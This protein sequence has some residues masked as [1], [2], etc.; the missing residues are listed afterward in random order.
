[1]STL[2]ENGHVVT[3]NAGREVFDGGYVL[4]GDDGRIT[5]AGPAGTAPNP[6]CISPRPNACT[7]DSSGAPWN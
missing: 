1:M 5:S 3:M 6:R 2:I 7:F 4:V